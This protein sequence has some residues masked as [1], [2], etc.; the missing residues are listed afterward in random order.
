MNTAKHRQNEHICSAGTGTGFFRMKKRA[1]LLLTAFL[2]LAAGCAPK[3]QAAAETPEPTPVPVQETPS[4]EPVVL[5]P[6]QAAMEQY[7]AVIPQAGSYTYA[8]FDTKPSGSYRYALERFSPDD[9]IPVLLLE[10]ESTDGNHYCIFFIYDE[11]SPEPVHPARWFAEGNALIAGYRASMYMEGD[12]NGLLLTETSP[13]SGNTDISRITI[14]DGFVSVSLQWEGKTS[15][16]PQSIPY[17]EI[18]WY[19][20]GDLSGFEQWTEQ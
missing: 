9:E 1:E 5:T 7:R 8:S 15:G 12:G 16:V 3:E 17:R 4:A 19:D 20:A 13:R 18:T 11:E 14:E 10:Q 6:L 2:V